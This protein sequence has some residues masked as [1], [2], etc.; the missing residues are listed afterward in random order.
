MYVYIHTM[1]MSHIPVLPGPADG[2]WRRGRLQAPWSIA[3]RASPQ[4]SRR[5]PWQRR[6]PLGPSPSGP[7]GCGELQAPWLRVQR[8]VLRK[9]HSRMVTYLVTHRA[10]PPRLPLLSPH[11]PRTITASQE[12]PDKKWAIVANC[13]GCNCQRQITTCT[14][15]S[16]IWYKA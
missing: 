14:R 12:A 6:W 5:P 4:A 10:Q 11:A 9:E 2:P 3:V 7:A 1:H 8:D 16:V 13:K 15:S